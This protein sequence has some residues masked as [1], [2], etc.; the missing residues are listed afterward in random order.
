MNLK[1]TLQTA[2][3]TAAL[4]TLSVGSYFSFSSSGRTLARSHF[5]EKQ[6]NA[7]LP[8]IMQAL[9]NE[10]GITFNVTPKIEARELNPNTNSDYD[11]KDNTIVL[12]QNS[13]MLSTRGTW[14]YNLSCYGACVPQSESIRHG[15]ARHYIDEHREEQGKLGFFNEKSSGAAGR[16]L[17]MVMLRALVSKGIAHHFQ[18]SRYTSLPDEH[19][20]NQLERAS[21]KF[22]RYQDLA[23]LGNTLV[24]PIILDHR[25][26]GIDYLIENPPENFNNLTEYQA[27]ALKELKEAK[28][29][30]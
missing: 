6:A 22:T 12:N 3:I 19:D 11:P 24:T 20:Q 9:E 30:L 25:K 5:L 8:N 27:T 21:F 15:L 17:E 10:L 29:T 13:G 18:N 26:A 1:T 4:T 7:K 28:S 16:D 23:R 2:F 14:H